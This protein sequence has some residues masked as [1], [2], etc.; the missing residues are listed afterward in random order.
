MK[1]FPKKPHITL[2]TQ[3]GTLMAVKTFLF[4]VHNSYGKEKFKSNGFFTKIAKHQ[5]YNQA[6]EFHP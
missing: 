1:V 2:K 5:I 3:K 6:K 4:S